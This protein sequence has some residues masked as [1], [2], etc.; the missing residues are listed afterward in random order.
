MT[1]SQKI[2]RNK[3]GLP[4]LAKQ[5]GNVSQACRIM[6]RCPYDAYPLSESC[7][8]ETTY[9]GAYALAR[10]RLDARQSSYWFQKERAN[11][12]RAATWHIRQRL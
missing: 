4:E 8:R 6:V 5:L 1:T 3:V 10:L 7:C 9:C 11:G 12:C 2:L